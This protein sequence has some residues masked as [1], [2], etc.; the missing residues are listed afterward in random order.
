MTRSPYR[1]PL[2]P[3][4]SAARARPADAL[5]RVATATLIA[6]QR[7]S[8][9]HSGVADILSD[10][11]ADDEV[12]P[13][14]LRAAS[15]PA[16]TTSANWAGSLANASF[17]DFIGMTGPASVAATLLSR[18]LQ[19]NFGPSANVIIPGLVASASNTSFVQQGAPFPSVN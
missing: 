9:P 7:R 14:L 4:Y 6:H 16:T 13:F 11:Y 12:G 1:I 15:V 19:L 10:L 2:R 5:L 17:A 8:Q 3:D 18:A